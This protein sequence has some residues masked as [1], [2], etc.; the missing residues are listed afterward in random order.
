MD[1]IQDQQLKGLPGLGSLYLLKN[2]GPTDKRKSMFWE[3][4]ARGDENSMS[5]GRE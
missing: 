4:M 5:K 3:Q 2:G 1:S